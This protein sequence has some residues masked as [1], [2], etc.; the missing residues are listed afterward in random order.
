MRFF[1]AKPD[2][3]FLAITIGLLVFGLVTL[4]SATGPM[5]YQRFHDSYYF[6][7]H[8]L[9]FGVLPG[10]VVLGVMMYIPYRTWKRLAVPLLVFS[11]ILLVLVFIPGIR[12]NFGTAKS[13]IAFGPF[14]FQPSEIVKLTF[15]FYLAAWLESRGARGVRDFRTGFIPFFLVLGVVIGLLVLEPDTGSMAIIAIESLAVFFVA[16]SSL[17]HL[18]VLGGIGVGLLGLL[19]K[20]SPYRAARLMTFMHPELDP[21]G[22][23]YHV[24]QAMLAI[25]SGGFWGFGLGHSRQKFQYLPEVQGDSL[26]AIIGEELGFIFAAGLLCAYFVFAWRGLQIADRVPDYFGKFV[27]IGIVSWLSFQAMVNICAMIGLL[28]LTGVTLPFVSYGGTAMI[29]NLAAVGVVLNISK[30][31]R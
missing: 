14:S 2:L 20:L 29:A 24:N 30:E 26:F 22:I 13:W 5:G 8:Q 21:Q 1:R 18:G 15:L 4:A 28:P 16:G 17:L 9:L 19:I 7:K 27:T 3:V 10:L 31:K 25:G 11:I 12:A 6:L 23:G